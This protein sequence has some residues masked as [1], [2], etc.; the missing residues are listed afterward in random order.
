MNHYSRGVPSPYIMIIYKI[1][2]KS[3]SQNL[4]RLD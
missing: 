3:H 2:D 4:D 1:L